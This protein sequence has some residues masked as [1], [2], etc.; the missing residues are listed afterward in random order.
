MGEVAPKNIVAKVGRELSGYERIKAELQDN[1][2]LDPQ[3][4]LD[5]LEGETNLNETLMAVAEHIQ[6]IEALNVG[7]KYHI[8]ALQERFSRQKKATE[9]LRNVILSAMDRAEIKTIRGP[10]FTLTVRDTKPVAIVDDEVLVPAGFFVP[11]DPKLDKKALSEAL[12]EGVEIPGAHLTNGGISL[13][14][15]VK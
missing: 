13:T 8:D 10:L 7:L 12:N 2:D 9:T 6:E 15:R 5:T 4:L 1:Y 11:Q 3:T 14:V